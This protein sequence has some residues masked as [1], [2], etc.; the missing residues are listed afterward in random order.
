MDGSGAW[1]N[2]NM[3][4]T[5]AVS[6]RYKYIFGINNVDIFRGITADASRYVRFDVEDRPVAMCGCRYNTESR[7][8]RFLC[9]F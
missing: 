7:R 3:Y 9:F 5:T 4:V 8:A 1:A 6:L 2:M